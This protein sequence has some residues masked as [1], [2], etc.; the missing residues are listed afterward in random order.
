MP[1]A[2]LEVFPGTSLR[3]SVEVDG[4]PC[5]HGFVTLYGPASVLAPI[6]EHGTVSADGLFP[7]RY[8]VVAR[9]VG[10]ADDRETL[11]VGAS[12]VERVWKLSPGRL[13]TGVVK[14]ADGAA[15]AAVAISVVPVGGAGRRSPSGCLSDGDGHFSCAGLQAGVHHCFA[16]REGVPVSKAVPV[17]IGSGDV[18]SVELRLRGSA[19]VRVR[20]V[21]AGRPVDHAAV[22]AWREGEEIAAARRVGSGSTRFPPLSLGVYAIATGRDAESRRRGETVRLDRDGEVATVTLTAPVSSTATI[23]GRAVSETGQPSPMPGFARRR[24]TSGPSIR[25]PRRRP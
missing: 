17:T 25:T 19:T 7:G 18:G 20:V 1:V 13:V 8:T 24:R 6:A 14:G 16:T 2:R 23:E 11:E 3:G 21:A 10:A 9:C 5:A 4:R 15:A 12:P 22:V